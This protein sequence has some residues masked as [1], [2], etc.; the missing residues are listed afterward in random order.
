M[1]YCKKMQNIAKQIAKKNCKNKWRGLRIFSDACP[2][3]FPFSVF[4][5][6]PGDLGLFGALLQ[7]PAPEKKKMLK[8][9]D[10]ILLKY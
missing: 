1:K 3:P 5:F 7:P 2:L 9:F 4:P 10:E 6:W 8:K